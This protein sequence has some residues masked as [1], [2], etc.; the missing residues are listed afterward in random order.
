MAPRDL[1]L[2]FQ[3]WAATAKQS[4]DPRSKPR[5]LGYGPLSSYKYFIHVDE[6]A[7]H[8]FLNPGEG[9]ASMSLRRGWVHLVDSEWKHIDGE[10]DEGLEPGAE[11]FEPLYGCTDEDVG[12]L[13]LSGDSLNH[14]YYDFLGEENEVWYI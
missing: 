3:E 7:L 1:K 14:S 8:S 6:P 5:A 2:R 12:W 4:E 10:G 9:A 13:K 11:G